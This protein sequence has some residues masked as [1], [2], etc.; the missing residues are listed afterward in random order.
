MVKRRDLKQVH[1]NAVL[2]QFSKYMENLGIT[3]D[4]LETPD[5]PEAIIEINGK[6]TWLEVTDAFLDKDHAIGLT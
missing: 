5:P 6:K 1:E 3:L 2:Q 4:V